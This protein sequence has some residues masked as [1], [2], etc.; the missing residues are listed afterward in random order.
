MNKNGM[1]SEFTDL[2]SVSAFSHDNRLNGPFMDTPRRILEEDLKKLKTNYFSH[3]LFCPSENSIVLDTDANSGMFPIYFASLGKNIHVLAVE[4]RPDLFLSLKKTI[5][6]SAL[7]NIGCFQSLDE[8]LS[9]A[10]NLCREKRSYIDLIKMGRNSFE[11]ESLKQITQEF[12]VG[13]LCGEFIGHD[14]TAVDVFRL[15]TRSANTFLWQNISKNN[16]ISG[17][18]NNDT[19]VSIVVPVYNVEEYLPKCIDSLVKQTIKSKEILLVD[20]GSTDSS[21]HIADEWS[22]NYPEIRVIH[23]QNAGCA[24]ARSKGLAEARGKFV[25]F[26][27]SDDWVDAEMFEKLFEAAVINNAEVAQCGFR[28]VYEENNVIEPYYEESS[29]TGPPYSNKVVDNV[30]D[31]MVSMPSIWRRIYRIEFLKGKGIDFLHTLPRFD[32]LPFQFEVFMHTCKMVSVPGAY[33][34]YRLGRM[35]QD[36]AAR[37]ERLYVHFDIFKHLRERLATKPRIEF[38]RQLKRVE[39]AT[40]EW[41]LSNIERPL[42]RRY[43]IMAAKDIFHN[44]LMISRLR[45]L[46]DAMKESKLKGVKIFIALML[47]FILPRV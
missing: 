7:S 38:E 6:K 3:G 40:H 39:I 23:Q 2:S 5:E 8:A 11:L 18:G 35:G 41:A 1:T 44:R 32:D 16:Q 22:K 31:I 28:K 20:D 17:Y 42:K 34:N 47:S 21:G 10:R 36:V 29:F 4:T 33:Y 45:I 13:H 14:S 37:D 27:D 15:S 43:Q 24:A 25:G 46:K 26:V 30:L 19:E 9:T 12:D